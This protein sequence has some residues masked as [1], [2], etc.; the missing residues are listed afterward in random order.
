M[1]S[2][3]TALNEA[4]KECGYVQ[5]QR[6]PGLNYS[7]AGEAALIEAIRPVLLSHGVVV[8]QSGISDIKHDQ[9]ATAKGTIQNRVVATYSFTFAHISG[10]SITVTAMGEGVDAGDKAAYKANTG[11]LKYAIRQTLLIE[12][13]DDPDKETPEER[14]PEPSAEDL[15]RHK[16]NEEKADK[17]VIRAVEALEPMDAFGRGQWISDNPKAVEMLR[18]VKNNFPNKMRAIED[19]GVEV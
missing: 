18:W 6:T 19:L 3:I 8:Y 7:Y 10:E 15:K 11:A 5:K 16:V 1:K 14:A 4:Y 2:I 13:G 12:T 9:Y 17:L